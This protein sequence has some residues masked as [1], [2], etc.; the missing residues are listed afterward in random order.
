[1]PFDVSILL[2][3]LAFLFGF[4]SV[5]TAATFAFSVSLSVADSLSELLDDSMV[6]L[7]AFTPRNLG[8]GF[9]SASGSYGRALSTSLAIRST[10]FTVFGLCDATMAV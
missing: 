6:F 4:P 9:E 8:F 5:L 3:V 10:S 2:A 1:M 7:T